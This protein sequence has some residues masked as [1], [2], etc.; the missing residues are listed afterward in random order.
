MFAGK[1]LVHE[2]EKDRFDSL[3]VTHYVILNP[4]YDSGCPR[5]FLELPITDRG[6]WIETS[7]EAA[8]NF[9]NRFQ[10][11]IKPE[12]FLERPLVPGDSQNAEPL[13]S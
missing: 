10:L 12:P 2:V 8:I 11:M 1:I 7:P 5:V 4:G 6:Y 13:P 9:T 3:A